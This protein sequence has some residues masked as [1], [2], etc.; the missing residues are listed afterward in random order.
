MDT[1]RLKRF[2]QDARRDLQKIVKA[3]LPLALAENSAARRE[4]PQAV[5]ELKKALKKQGDEALIDK[6]AYTWFNRFCALRFMDVMGYN[7]IRIVSPLP[8]HFQPEI[9]EEAKGGNIDETFVA[10][11]KYRA[12]IKGLLDGSIPAVD[13][14][15]EAYKLL[16]V[17]ACNAYNKVMPFLF[18][19]IDDYTEL[20]LPDDLMKEN[21]ILMK[22][23]DA[24]TED[25]A[26]DG[27]EVIGWLYQFYI[28]EKKDEVMGKTVK[29]EDI[30][31][32][33]Q[34]FTPDWIVRYLVQN[35]LGRLWMLN[36]PNSKLADDMEYYIPVDSD[37]WVVGS[38]EW[39]DICGK[40]VKKE[41][42]A[43][44]VCKELSRI[45][46][47]AEEYGVGN[48]HISTVNAFAEG[49]NTCTV[50]SDAQSSGLNT[51]QYSRGT[52]KKLYE[53]IR[54]LSVDSTGLQGRIG[55][56]TYD[57]CSPEILDAI[58]SGNGSELV[59]RGWKD[60]ER[61]DWET[62][63][64][65]I[66]NASKNSNT[67]H[68]PLPTTHLKIS[69]PEEIRI[70]DPCCGSGHMLTYA[71]DL[72]VKI[73]EEEGY[74][75]RKIPTLILLKNLHGV[76]I[77]T[78]AG[79]LAAFALTMKA[80]EYDSRF[81]RRENAPYP[82]ICV[83]QNIA[84]DEGEI[85]QYMDAIG[86]DLFTESL[87]QTLH[88][89]TQADCFG[90]LIVPKISNAAS[91]MDVL[92]ERGVEAELFLAKVH[93]KVLDVINQADYL[94]QKYHVVVTNP[95]YMGGKGM[96]ADLKRFAERLYPDSKSDLFAMFIERCLQ[97]VQH[98]GTIGMITMQS[99]M[100]LSSFE[101]LRT[102]LLDENTILSMAHLGAR[103]FDSIG[104]EV[105][106][107][108]AFTMTNTFIPDYKGA[109]IRLVDGNNE[110]EKAA[111][112]QEAVR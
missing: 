83:L 2:A 70:C 48:A 99:W 13:G 71:F 17:S 68:Y 107:T 57:L 93:D 103:G 6:I 35:S 28:S 80:R 108:T 67:T 7:S 49:R 11:S 42:V 81:L 66:D 31:A 37:E 4:K 106:Q 46:G 15:A 101:K 92:T 55:N 47:L 27:V 23:R 30:P 56:P 85:P 64:A 91:I 84:F 109:F 95:P 20:L 34:L 12:R 39:V 1:N 61:I 110:A 78:R 97:L 22:T 38:D 43:K 72:L 51:I 112:F 76:E 32:A 19:K 24:L 21:S 8:G 63:H 74:D 73:Y 77:D 111:M 82:Q 54:E 10:D 50:K 26:A 90:S 40:S 58:A 62:L 104:G 102:K 16:L 9:L 36:H 53:G 14:Q 100:F 94:S 29:T 5:A 59:R 105:V 79:E 60:A 25:V 69:S 65:L 41:E 75:R 89:F 33:T 98:Q 86:H 96:N 87:Q 88:Q 44:Y 52:S 3:L 18:Q 45:T